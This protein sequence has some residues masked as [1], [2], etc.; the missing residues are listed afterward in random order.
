MLSEIATVDQLG[1]LFTKG[2]PRETFEYLRNF[3]LLLVRSP[4]SHS[5]FIIGWWNS[6]SEQRLWRHYTLSLI[7]LKLLCSVPVGAPCLMQV[8]LSVVLRPAPLDLLAP[9]D[10]SSPVPPTVPSIALSDSDSYSVNAFVLGSAASAYSTLYRAPFRSI[11][12]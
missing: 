3:L 7:S 1:D 11:P 6:N 10:V 12:V 8:K 4:W 5:V 2:L 9:R